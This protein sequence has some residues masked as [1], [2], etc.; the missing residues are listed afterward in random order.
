[1]KPSAHKL[2]AVEINPSMVGALFTDRNGDQMRLC[3]YYA[4]GDTVQFDVPEHENRDSLQNLFSKL[5]MASGC[6]S[7]ILEKVVRG[8]VYGERDG[9]LQLYTLLATAGDELPAI[10]ANICDLPWQ[11]VWASSEAEVLRLTDAKRDWDC[12]AIRSLVS[13]VDAEKL[14]RSAHAFVNPTTI[15]AKKQNFRLA[16]SHVVT[17]ALLLVAV[18]LGWILG[19]QSNKG[20]PVRAVELPVRQSAAP[21]VET[22]KASPDLRVQ[23]LSARKISGP[24]SLAEVE[25]MKAEGTLPADAV[26]RTEG[27]TEWISPGE[28]TKTPAPGG[29]KQ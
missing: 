11:V 18:G 2:H 13:P 10:Q 16:A 26:F 14:Y 21:V 6:T 17:A 5:D 28:V 24:F 22:P 20:I 15:P 8:R 19:Y 9:K 4:N 29:N 1:M 7:V 12:Y 27:T 3:V 25:N 23:M